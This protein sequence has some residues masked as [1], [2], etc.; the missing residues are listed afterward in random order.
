MS[1]RSENTYIRQAWMLLERH[2][3]WTQW[4]KW[5]KWIIPQWDCGRMRETALFKPLTA[6]SLHYLTLSLKSYLWAVTVQILFSSFTTQ[7]EV[8]LAVISISHWL[9]WKMITCNLVVLYRTTACNSMEMYKTTP[10]NCMELHGIAVC[11]G[12]E[13]YRMPA[14]GEMQ[15]RAFLPSWGWSARDSLGM[16]IWNW[17]WRKEWMR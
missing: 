8:G 3:K 9:H 7:Y 1:S 6:L 11:N 12:M 10:C 15:G 16:R 4:L 14:C 2:W 5:L 17:P 13:I